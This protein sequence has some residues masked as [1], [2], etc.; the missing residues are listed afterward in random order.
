MILDK[1]ET[2]DPSGIRTPDHLIRGLVTTP[3]TLSRFLWGYFMALG[4][5]CLWGTFEKLRKATINVCRVCP[6]AHT[7]QLDYHRT[8]FYR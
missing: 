8:N 3:T 5:T 6:S 7:K 4:N 2:F 1:R